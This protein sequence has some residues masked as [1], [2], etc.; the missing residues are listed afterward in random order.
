M[1]LLGSGC[2]GSESPEPCRDKLGCVDVAPE[3]PVRI[4]AI[5]V[6][7]GGIQVGGVNQVRAIQM[8]LD[9]RGGRLLGHPLALEVE[10]GRCSKE[11]GR[12]AAQKIASDPG[13]VG[14]LGAT[15]SSSS[16]AAARVLSEAGLVL[17][18]ASSTAP[19]LTSTGGVPGADR[20]LGFFRTIHNDA[21][22]GAAAAAY[23]RESLGAVRAGVV[24]DGGPYGQ[25]LA[26]AFRDA[27]SRFGGETALVAEVDK[28]DEDMGPVLAAV[29]ES[30]ADVLFFPLFRPASIRLL[31]Q[32]RQVKGLDRT[33]MLSSDA[34]FAAAFFSEA[35][36]LA[37]GL[38]F[39]LPFTPESGEKDAFEAEYVKRYG[40]PP[41]GIFHAYAYDAANLLLDAVAGVAVP[42]PQGG[43]RIGRQA[44]RDALH[45]V[46]G[47]HGLTGVLTCDSYG[48]CGAPRFK[49]VRVDDPDAGIESAASNVRYVFEPKRPSPEPGRGGGPS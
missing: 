14:V 23:V 19:S 20:Q 37:M 16:S 33:V 45:R 43:L 35:G 32:A 18:S 44:L 27:M 26:G 31:R 1:I 48:D 29:E 30:R 24:H 21:A 3:G 39:V 13:I 22:A 40:E 38:Q 6:L 2:S 11:G 42:T 34:S 12:V 28:D 5:Q 8:A 41:V 17:I 49:V 10:D 7:S 36:S 46:A 15:C 47:Y 4:A 9:S 25:G